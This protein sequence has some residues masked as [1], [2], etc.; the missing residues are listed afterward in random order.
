[1][2]LIERLRV[3]LDKNRIG[4]AFQLDDVT[5][6]NRVA[7]YLLLVTGCAGDYKITERQDY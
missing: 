6:S 3:L 5:H 4:P 1:M 2:Y 7:F